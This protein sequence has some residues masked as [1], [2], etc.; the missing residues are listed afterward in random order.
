MFSEADSGET[1]RTRRFGELR[2]SAEGE[3]L[4]H[5]HRDHLPVTTALK[6]MA[7]ERRR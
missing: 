1:E 7:R 3:I 5:F 4:G 2:R 6:P